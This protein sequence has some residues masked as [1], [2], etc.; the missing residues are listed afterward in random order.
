MIYSAMGISMKNN[1]ILV[2]VHFGICTIYELFRDY[3]I[4]GL[5]SYKL[6][7]ATSCYETTVYEQVK[8]SS[9][10]KRLVRGEKSLRRRSAI[11]NNCFSKLTMYRS[12]HTIYNSIHVYQ[13]TGTSII[14]INFDFFFISFQFLAYG[15][16]PVLYYKIACSKKRVFILFIDAYS[17]IQGLE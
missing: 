7:T 12:P 6:F 5:T 1:Y 10:R 3:I 9:R 17:Y 2:L 11:K 15:L 16:M 14:R 8:T 4:P 13:N